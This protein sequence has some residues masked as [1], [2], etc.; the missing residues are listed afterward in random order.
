M[1]K[2]YALFFICFIALSVNA[3][4][5][6]NSAPATMPYGKIGKEDLE[7]KACDFEKDAN[8]EI[9]FDKGEVSFDPYYEVVFERH[10]RIKIFNDKGKNAA[11]VHLEYYGGH[12]L[13][14]ITT[15]E[16]E[17][18]NLNNGK[19]EFTKVDKKSIYQ[20]KEDRVRSA[21]IFSFPNVQPGSVI[22][23][24]YSIL[25]RSPWSVPNWYFQNNIPVRYSEIKTSIP[26]IL[27]YKNLEWVTQPFVIN[28]P[29]L[30]A[31]ANI[32]SFQDEPYMG[33]RKDNLERIQFQLTTISSGTLYKQFSS[34]WKKIGEEELNFTDFGEQLNRKLKDEGIILAQAKTL[35]LADDKIACIFNAVK[36]RMKWNLFDDAYTTDGTAEAWD[37]KVGNSTEVNLILYHLL[38]KAGVNAYPMKVSTKENGKV[39]PAYP[40]RFQFNRT[41]VYLP[42]DSNKF[43]V[44]DATSKYNVYNEIPA[45]LLNGMG[46]YIDKDNEKYELQFLDN[47]NPIRQST[48]IIADVKPGGKMTG[49]ASI[50]SFGYSKREALKKYNDDGE[51][52]YYDYLKD[53]DNNIK[54]A[55][56]KFEDMDVDSL[57]LIQKI[58]F[59][60]ELAGS[61]DNYIYINPNLFTPFKTNP[62]LNDTRITDI[63]F[64]YCNNYVI[65]GIYK[66]PAGYK[67]DGLPKNINMTMPDNSITFKRIASE[68]N[69][70]IV[71]RYFIVYKKSVYFKEDYPEIHEFYK[72]M[73][74]LLNEQ[75]VLKKA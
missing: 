55:S 30:K 67:V 36:T 16:A 69:G 54:I 29:D 26:S 13:E 38:H 62:F 48:S 15:I 18:I 20:Q 47:T 28:K 33:A 71:I 22:E 14:T 39:N 72:K 64:Q 52:K 44:L 11:N 6:N 2:F 49:T 73:Y 70:G 51:K 46:F 68:E 42:V 65:N 74:E 21:M 17:T 8:A 10:V 5:A 40:D 53:K 60:Q 43:Y 32:P 34:S 31:V 50:Y 61:D 1:H 37:K 57:P 23:F 35:K 56:L 19:I 45:A 58:E 12:G 59:N 24:K 7:M 75:I 3:Q 27:Y 4:K 25:G 63:D 66:T 9:L 41:V